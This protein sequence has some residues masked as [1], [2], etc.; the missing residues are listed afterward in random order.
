MVL[1]ILLAV[2]RFSDSESREMSVHDKECW[3]HK[4]PLRIQQNSS[5]LPS[6]TR[7]RYRAKV[8]AF[9]DSLQ[10]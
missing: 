1:D 5:L 9:V 6:N 8:E 2:S 10:K 7:K 4:S 3:W